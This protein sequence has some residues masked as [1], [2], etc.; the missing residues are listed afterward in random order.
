MSLKTLINQQLLDNMSQAQKIVE[1][2]L[3][4]RSQRKIKIKQPLA[5]GRINVTLED[6]YLDIIREELNLKSLLIDPS[7]SQLVTMIVKPN[8]RVL[9]KRLGGAMQDVIREAK[10]G[11]YTQ[12]EAGQIQVGDHII[13]SDEYEVE[14]Q[15]ADAG[16]DVVVD[17]DTVLVL[18]MAITPELKL[19]WDARELVRAIQDARKSSWYDV[20]DRIQLSITGAPEELISGFSEYICGETLATLVTEITAPDALIEVD[21][22]EYKI[23]FS[24]KR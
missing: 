2:W 22:D 14:Y 5:S 12:L 7:I 21:C 16:V 11:N 17:R 24:I 1:L 4:L 8:A 18:D 9:G 6:Y 19:E 15:S 20:S 23:Q 10:A 3:S 13:S